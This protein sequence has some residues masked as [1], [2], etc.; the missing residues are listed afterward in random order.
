MYRTYIGG[1]VLQEAGGGAALIFQPS[2]LNFGF[3]EDKRKAKRTYTY[4]KLREMKAKLEGIISAYNFNENVCFLHFHSQSFTKC[5]R[6]GPSGGAVLIFQPPVLNFG[7]CVEDKG[8]Y[9]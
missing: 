1:E 6:G 3:V 4:G 2:V 8:T 7:Y 9:L 5:R